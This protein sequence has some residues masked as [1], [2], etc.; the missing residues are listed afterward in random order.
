PTA[1]RTGG[2]APAAGA[3]GGAGAPST[4]SP[5]LAHLAATS[6]DR[7]V[8][9]II[10]LKRGVALAAGRAL[11]RS[12][13]GLPGAGLQIINGLSATLTAA[14]ART[15]A[16]SPKIHA[17]SLNSVLRSTWRRGT[18]APWQLSTTYDQ[19][20]HASGLWPRSTG[21]GVGVAVIDTGI[22]G[23]LPDFQA[24]RWAS[25]PRLAPFPVADPTASPAADTYG[26]G[27]AVAGLVPR[28]TH[29]RN[30]N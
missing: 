8:V 9:A 12:V 29:V 18:P 6:P 14:D 11:V 19:S 27:T 20:V 4:L 26:H 24:P 7:R 21:R 30:W 13:G 16:A 3:S 2:T 28:N 25:P 15:L 5:T 23:D 22:T 1:L 17:V 10:Q